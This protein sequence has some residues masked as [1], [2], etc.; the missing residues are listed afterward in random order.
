M[1]A[2][3]TERAEALK[4]LTKW[5]LTLGAI[6]TKG[7]CHGGW[8]K[9]LRSLGYSDGRCDLTRTVT[10]GDIASSNGA[11]DALWCARCLPDGARRDVVRALL[12]AVVRVARHTRDDRVHA[13]ITTLRRWIDGQAHDDELRKVAQ[14]AWAKWEAGSAAEAAALAAEAA[15][16]AASYSGRATW[17]AAAAAAASWSARV[18]AAALAKGAAEA[19]RSRQVEDIVAVFGRLT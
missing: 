7:P 16:A 9:L 6:R 10:L 13:C 2:P 11:A 3:T 5:P 1:M 19:E 4:L 8:E 17:S 18:A 14:S 12:P 15:A